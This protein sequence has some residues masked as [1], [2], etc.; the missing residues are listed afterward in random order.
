MSLV[1]AAACELTIYDSMESTEVH[2]VNFLFFCR[3]PTQRQI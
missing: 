1:L 3:H 2:A